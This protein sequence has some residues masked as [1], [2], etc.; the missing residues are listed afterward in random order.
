M[1]G[2]DAVEV[3]LLLLLLLLHLFCSS[4]VFLNHVPLVRCSYSEAIEGVLAHPEGML[5]PHQ[6]NTN[7]AVWKARMLSR[8]RAA[9][10]A[11]IQRMEAEKQE[12]EEKKAEK[13]KAA[14]A[15]ATK[16]GSASSTNKG[17][18]RQKVERDA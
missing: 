4:V 18:K 14:A 2:H 10:T 11:V 13:Q 1:S 12:A 16:K 3:G 5:P 9:K 6:G 15:A 8:I 7:S 17:R